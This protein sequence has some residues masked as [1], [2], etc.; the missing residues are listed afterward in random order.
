MQH[1]T[2]H[3]LLRRR[4]GHAKNLSVSNDSVPAEKEISPYIY[5]GFLV[6]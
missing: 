5:F 6:K 4:E 2:L 3:Q 1:F